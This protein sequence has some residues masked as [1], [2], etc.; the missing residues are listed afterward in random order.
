MHVG[1]HSVSSLTDEVKIVTR[2]IAL[3]CGVIVCGTVGFYVIEN[4]WTLW[5]SFYLTLI[6]I[7]TV[8]YG[9]E[10]MSEA[11]EVFAALLL[12]SGIGTATWAL[13]TVVQF[14]VVRQFDWSRRMRKRVRHMQ[15]H[16]IICGFGR[17]GQTLC[18]ELT[19]AGIPFVIVDKSAEAV[20]DAVARKFVTLQ[21]DSTDEAMLNEAGLGRARGLVSC[22]DS[23]SE[24]VMITLTARDLNPDL[25]IA[26]RANSEASVPRLKRAGATYVVSPYTTAGFDIARAIAKPHL[27]ELLRNAHRP[28][29]DFAMSEIRIEPDSILTE[30]TP[31]T[32]GQTEG[33]IAFIAIRRDGS[34]LIFRP[35][36]QKRFLA[37]DVLIAAGK[38]DAMARM[39][40]AARTPL[41]IRKEA[42]AAEASLRPV[43]T[44]G[45]ALS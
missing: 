6:T 37:N 7:T 27:A 18:E 31:A 22:V 1:S 45:P 10:G 19:E 42:V 35:A 2:A 39:A 17:I 32:Y 11:S 21:G 24:N 14:T 40:V 12:V 23:D 15:D 8:G 44:L 5:R 20:A 16:I 30:A 41:A 9:D 25:F 36:G 33:S 26:T 3:L 29:G 28:D 34:E 43:A 38:T 13:S 4:D